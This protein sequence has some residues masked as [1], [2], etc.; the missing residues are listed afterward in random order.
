M[1]VEITKVRQIPDEPE[2]RWFSSE[3]MDLIVWQKAGELIGFQLSYD[4]LADEHA[5]SWHV[6][7]GLMHHKV[8]D[9]ESR[10]GHYKATPIL[11][12]DG[13]A[14]I[15]KVIQQFEESSDEIDATIRQFVLTHLTVYN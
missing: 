12:E 7:K 5:L 11:V 1:L 8:D 3:F 15:E 6:D 4:K 9:G 14:N 10:S 13:K 2:R